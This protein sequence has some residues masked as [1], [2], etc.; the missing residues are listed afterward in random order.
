MTNKRTKM[1]SWWHNGSKNPLCRLFVLLLERPCATAGIH[2]SV[3]QLSFFLSLHDGLA[4]YTSHQM[5]RYLGYRFFE[6]INFFQ[7]SIFLNLQKLERSTN[8]LMPQSL[9]VS[10]TNGEIYNFSMFLSF[11]ETFQLCTQLTNLAMKQLDDYRS[12]EQFTD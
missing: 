8:A 6:R 10:T 5:E 7:L 9:C 2:L 4:D 12:I 11:D 1:I 3:C